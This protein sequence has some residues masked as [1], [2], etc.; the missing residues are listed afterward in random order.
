ME[1]VCFASA[2]ERSMKSGYFR[3]SS[4]AV[5]RVSG[6]FWVDECVCLCGCMCGCVR[7]AGG[8]WHMAGWIDKQQLAFNSQHRVNPWDPQTPEGSETACVWK[9]EWERD[10]EVQ[11]TGGWWR[12][13]QGVCIVTTSLRQNHCMKSI[14]IKNIP[15]HESI[16]MNWYYIT[17]IMKMARSS[18]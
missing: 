4:E 15:A 14:F 13:W 11:V 8:H 5:R 9:R 1:E 6:V 16:H 12:K 17:N 18:H 3:S 2:D 10:R 7:R